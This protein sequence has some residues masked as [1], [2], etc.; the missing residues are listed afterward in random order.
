MSYGEV[1]GDSRM[2]AE[3]EVFRGHYAKLYN[4][5]HNA[6]ALAIQFY[7][8]GL[9]AKELRTNIL[10]STKTSEKNELLLRAL[11]EVV[12]VNSRRFKDV[13][14]VFLKEPYLQEIVESM[15]SETSHQSCDY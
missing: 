2:N 8:S 11:E 4:L 15:R 1:P 14:E 6:D 3:G 9:I 12:H 7:S 13:M 10:E 5:I